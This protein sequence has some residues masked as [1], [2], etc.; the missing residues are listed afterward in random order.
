MSLSCSNESKSPEKQVK[1]LCRFRRI[2]RA[3]RPKRVVSQAIS[4]S[5]QSDRPLYNHH[6]MR[7]AIRHLPLVYSTNTSSVRDDESRLPYAYALFVCQ[8]PTDEACFRTFGDGNAGS[9]G[10]PDIGTPSIQLLYVP[11]R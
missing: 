9:P 6:S 2:D 11:I 5:L 7:R 4:V 3:G 10:H 1:D 8:A